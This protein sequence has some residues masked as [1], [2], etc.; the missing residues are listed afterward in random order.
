MEV[1]D[2]VEKSPNPNYRGPFIMQRSLKDVVSGSI[3]FPNKFDPVVD[4]IYHGF[5]VDCLNN[6]EFW[7]HIQWVNDSILVNGRV[8]VNRFDPIVNSDDEEITIA[9][10]N[11]PEVHLVVNN[12]KS[13][14]RRV[15]IISGGQTGADRAGLDVAIELG[16]KYGGWVPKGRKSEDGRVPDKYKNMKE[17]NSSYYPERTELNIIDSDFTIIFSIGKP[18]PG[19]VLTANK[20][21]QH[22]KPYCFV[23]FLKPLHVDEIGWKLLNVSDLK[24]LNI[25]G[26]RHQQIYEPV[27][28][29]LKELLS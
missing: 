4:S 20:A 29:F 26:S 24:V 17:A 8:G 14:L 19:S 3:G 5:R 12:P 25:A 11:N 18:G 16:M 15:K 22:C 21:K 2:L 7:L 10:K 6:P 13:I 23:D 1:N 9:C 27:K 28:K